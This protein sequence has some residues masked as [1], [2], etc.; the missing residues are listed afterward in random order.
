MVGIGRR[1]SRS[2]YSR[3]EW[4]SEPESF[5]NRL[6]EFFNFFPEIG[7]PA[8]APDAARVLSASRLLLRSSDVRATPIV[9]D[10]IC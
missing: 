2:E 3:P 1:G 5:E 7:R 4:E 9:R 6:L 8:A 10:V